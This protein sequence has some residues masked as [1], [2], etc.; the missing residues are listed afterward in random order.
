MFQMEGVSLGQLWCQ[1]R[2]NVSATTYQALLTEQMVKLHV[3]AE[4]N[5]HWY[6]AVVV[7]LYL[8]GVVLIVKREGHNDCTDAAATTAFVECVSR[9]DCVNV[10]EDSSGDEGGTVITWSPHQS[11]QMLLMVVEDKHHTEG[12]CCSTSV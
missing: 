7:S 10:D 9:S 12:G 1:C 11:L 3:N 6:V 8:L 4:R 5:G 2:G